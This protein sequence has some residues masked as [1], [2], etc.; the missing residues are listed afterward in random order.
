MVLER[1]APLLTLCDQSDTPLV[2]PQGLQDLLQLT[3]QTQ[4]KQEKTQTALMWRT[5]G[6]L[7]LMFDFAQQSVVDLRQQWDHFGQDSP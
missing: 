5:P 6:L 1:P 2:T 7:R 3:P 4:Q